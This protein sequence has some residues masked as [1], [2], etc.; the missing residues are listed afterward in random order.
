MICVSVLRRL[1]PWRHVLSILDTWGVRQL[2]GGGHEQCF[3]VLMQTI[4]E[5]V[6]LSLRNQLTMVFPVL[7]LSM[8]NFPKALLLSMLSELLS[9]LMLADLVPAGP[10]EF[11][12]ALESESESESVTVTVV[13]PASL[14]GKK[15][16][17][18]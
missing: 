12:S 9:A 15:L 4:A 5:A 8:L 6:Y 17:H 3:A 14:S 11:E 7:I 16:W 2:L 1:V 18:G 10:F 13:L